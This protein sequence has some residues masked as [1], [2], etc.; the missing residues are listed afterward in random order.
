[1]K[2]IE[3]DFAKVPFWKRKKKP[4]AS[5]KRTAE[6]IILEQNN[7]DLPLTIARQAS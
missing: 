5:D 6:K 3:R 7:I 4:M 1:M 2:T